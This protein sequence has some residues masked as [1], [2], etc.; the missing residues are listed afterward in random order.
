[1]PAN[2]AT[3][4]H[5]VCDNDKCPGNNLDP[6]DRQEW[7]F[8]TMEIYGQPTM[9]QQVF[10]SFAPCAAAH[11]GKMAR[12]EPPGGGPEAKPAEEEP[13]KKTRTKK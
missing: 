10:C 12:P 11:I 5:V 6:G 9:E 1:M 13:K 2:E 4:L 8:V 3:K 7:I